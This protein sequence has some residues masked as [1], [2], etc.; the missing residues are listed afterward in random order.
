M[1][2]HTNFL[3]KGGFK[4]TDLALTEGMVLAL[5]LWDDHYA[6][7]LW[8]DSTYPVGSSAPGA[9]RGTCSTDSGKPDDVETNHPDS[10]VTFSNIRFGDIGSTDGSGPSPPS[11]PSPGGC[12]GGSLQA[13]IGLCPSD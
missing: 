8:L 5:S 13:C 12:P 1:Q 9:A 6:N 11:P 2:D 10:S 7:M 3:E 4:A